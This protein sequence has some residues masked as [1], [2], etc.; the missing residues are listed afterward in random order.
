MGVVVVRCRPVI[1]VGNVVSNEHGDHPLSVDPAPIGSIWAPTN[2]GRPWHRDQHYGESQ[3]SGSGPLSRDGSLRSQPE[4]NPGV[5]PD[6]SDPRNAADG[7]HREWIDGAHVGVD[8][9]E[10]IT[11]TTQ[12]SIC[13]RGPMAPVQ[14]FHHVALGKGDLGMPFDV[15]REGGEQSRGETH[16]ARRRRHAQGE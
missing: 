1:A 9:L 5:R 12:Q 8:R 16:A 2:V 15:G 10:F 11:G 14:G 6:P 13:D 7:A 4:G 3:V